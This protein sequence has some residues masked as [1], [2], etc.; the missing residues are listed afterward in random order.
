MLSHLEKM[1]KIYPIA[2]AFFIAGTSLHSQ[3]LVMNPGFETYVPDSVNN[4]TGNNDVSK[5]EYWVNVG[6]GTSDYYHSDYNSPWPRVPNN[7]NGTQVPHG[8]NGYAGIYAFEI[9]PPI[10]NL[11]EYIRTQLIAPLAAGQA[12]EI[13]FYVSLAEYSNFAASF[14]ANLSA[15]PTNNFNGYLMLTTEHIH[16]PGAIT[17][18][19]NWTHVSGI[20]IAAGGEQYLTIGGFFDDQNSDTMTV[21]GIHPNA[22]YY[23]DDVSVQLSHAE[24]VNSQEL[25]N[26]FSL[27]PNPAHH[28]ITLNSVSGIAGNELLVFDAIGKQV[29]CTWTQTGERSFQADISSL[30]PGLYS[31]VSGT[32]GMRRRFLVAE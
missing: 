17:D 3:N 12:Y 24:D 13:S 20:Y 25:E 19:A 26:G 21:G 8:G 23:I 32:S 16:T 27:F 31:V 2:I 15:T 28:T 18:K 9:A 11:R 7:E 30:T 22:Y 10:V 4:S 6:P 5:A 1:K 14:G 29:A